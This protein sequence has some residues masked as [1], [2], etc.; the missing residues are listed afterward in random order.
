MFSRIKKELHKHPKLRNAVREARWQAKRV[1]IVGRLSIALD[2]AYFKNAG[3]ERPHADEHSGGDEYAKAYGTF[4]LSRVHGDVLDVGCGHG[5][6]TKQIA[7]R[8]DVASVIGV[9][10]IDDFLCADPKIKYFTKNL[11]DLT[12]NFP[13]TFDVVVAS[14]FIEHISEGDAE[15]VCKKV[16]RALRSEGAFIGST[17]YNPTKLKTF[18]GSRFHVREYNKKD[19]AALLGRSFGDVK[20]T[21]LP[22]HCLAWEARNPHIT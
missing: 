13:G 2:A 5:Y 12:E 3:D 16:A 15:K 14:E 7:A 22:V 19:L 1:P 10:K 11:T 18:S 21:V 8:P 4:I 17:P 9:D 20:I 6:L